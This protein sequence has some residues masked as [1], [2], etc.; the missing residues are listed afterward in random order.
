M[1]II[2]YAWLSS[3]YDIEQ[4]R[5]WICRAEDIQADARGKIVLQMKHRFDV[6]TVPEN[7][8]Y[9]NCA[10]LSDLVTDLISIIRSM[11]INELCEENVINLVSIQRIKLIRISTCAIGAYKYTATSS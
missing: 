1:Y 8:G 7:A 3:T 6:V 11:S 5:Q 4:C 9:G 2:E 10:L